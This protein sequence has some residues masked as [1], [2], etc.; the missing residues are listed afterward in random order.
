MVD[1]PANDDGVPVVYVCEAKVHA[2]VKDI[3]TRYERHA[4]RCFGVVSD[5]SAAREW[6]DERETRRYVERTLDVVSEPRSE[7]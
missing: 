5:E 1:L 7:V 4:W 2:D 6:V 3:G